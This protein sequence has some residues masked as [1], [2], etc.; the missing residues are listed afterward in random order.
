VERKTATCL[1]VWMME[2][3]S[4]SNASKSRFGSGGPC[5]LNCS[6]PVA[7]IPLWRPSHVPKHLCDDPKYKRKGRSCCNCLRSL[8]QSRE[9]VFKPRIRLPDFTTEAVK[10][11]IHRLTQPRR[12]IG[13][14]APWLPTGPLNFYNNL[15]VAHNQ[16]EIMANILGYLRLPVLASSGLAAL[17]SGLLYFKQ[18]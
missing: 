4:R 8:T 17:A 10:R 18:K 16:M 14:A 9:S 11:P 5:D 6:C 2:Q 1:K 7:L 13:T 15:S 3:G 12:S